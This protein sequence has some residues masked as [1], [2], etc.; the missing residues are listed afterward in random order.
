MGNDYVGKIS[1]CIKY[2]RPFVFIFKVTI[3]LT[4]AHYERW[5]TEMCCT[6]SE[7]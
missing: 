4:H 7:L 1:F 2:N 5:L 3:Y 6:L